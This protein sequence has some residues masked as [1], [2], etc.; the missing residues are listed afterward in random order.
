MKTTHYL[1]AVKSRY[2]FVSDYKLA[3]KLGITRASVSV[4]RNSK[5]FLGEDTSIF[6]GQLLEINPLIIISTA[7]AE[8][9]ARAGHEKQFIMWS[10]LAKKLSIEAGLQPVD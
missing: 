10:D 7:N 8:R 2:S 3:D 4:L 1:D 6:I 9:A 5:G